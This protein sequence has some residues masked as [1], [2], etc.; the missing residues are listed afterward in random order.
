MGG[1][2][3]MPALMASRTA[4]ATEYRKKLAAKGS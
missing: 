1:P 3:N 4:I 2:E